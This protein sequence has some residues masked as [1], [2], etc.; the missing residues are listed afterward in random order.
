MRAHPKRILV[1][2]HISEHGSSD[3]MDQFAGRRVVHEDMQSLFQNWILLRDRQAFWEGVA[4]GCSAVLRHRL[5]P[6]LHAI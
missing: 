1:S 6:L 3:L 2:R 5:Q 4:L